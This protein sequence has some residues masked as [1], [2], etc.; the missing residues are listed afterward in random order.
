MH[1]GYDIR[2]HPW[3][4]RT[5]PAAVCTSRRL[6]RHLRAAPDLTLLARD[7]M[8]RI[9]HA[10]DTAQPH[11]VADTFSHGTPDDIDTFFRAEYA[12][13]LSDGVQRDENVVSNRTAMPSLR[14]HA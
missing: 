7:L 5:C 9:V 8:Q 6:C 11:C 14:I 1:A 2:Y 4:Q 10:V 12:R 3:V 13:M